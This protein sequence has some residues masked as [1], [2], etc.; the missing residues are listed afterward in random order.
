[1][2]FTV[3]KTRG[4]KRL[5][6]LTF[7]GVHQSENLMMRSRRKLLQEIITEHNDYTESEE[8]TIGFRRS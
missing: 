6:L 7:T 5:H 4:A 8:R 1:M 3:Y 2:A